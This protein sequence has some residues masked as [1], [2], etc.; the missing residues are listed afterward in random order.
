[1]II[2]NKIYNMSVL[3]SIITSNQ[4]DGPGVDEKYLI[5]EV[6]NFKDIIKCI[7]CHNF[8]IKHTLCRYCK[9]MFCK[10]CISGWLVENE[11][12]PNCRDIFIES[13]LDRYS[14][15][16][17]KKFKLRCLNYHL[18]CRDEI[19]LED[20]EDHYITHCKFTIFTCEYCDYKGNIDVMIAHYCETECPYCN[21]KVHRSKKLDH[22]KICKNDLCDTCGK[23]I[24]KNKMK[25]HYDF[26][27]TERKVE[28][29]MCNFSCERKF[30]QEHRNASHFNAN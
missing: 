23:I 17:L 30:L 7:I 9:G 11:T 25:V 20:Y 18:G 29:D 4:V 15:Q 10:F 1:M 14:D 27:C 12:C 13:E 3:N 16:L 6:K 2:K 5:G 28:C 24:P 22:K 21:M 8:P 26:H 19:F